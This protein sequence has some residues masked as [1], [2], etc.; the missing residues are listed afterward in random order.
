MLQYKSLIQYTRV[1]DGVRFPQDLNEP[2]LLVYF[3][4]NSTF[5]NDY[6]KL[7]IRR[8]DLRHVVIPIT[9][10]PL[11]RLTPELR[12]Q[13]KQIQMLAYNSNM[14]YPTNKNLLYDTT[15]FTQTVDKT[16][17]PTTYRQRA[18]FLIQNLLRASFQDFADNYKKILIYSIDITKPVNSFVNRKVFALIKQLKENDIYFDDLILVIVDESSARYRQLIRDKSYKFGRVI[19]YLRSIKIQN[20]EEEK[21]E[22]IK[23]ATVKVMKSIAP[24]IEKPEGVKSAV[25]D[26]LKKHPQKAEELQNDELSAD[27]VDRLTVASILYK[28]SGNLEKSNRLAANIPAINVKTAVKKVSKQYEDDLLKK[29]PSVDLSE[30]VVVQT[31]NVPQRVDGKTPEHIFAKRRVDFETNLRKDMINAFKVL[32]GRDIPLKFDSISVKPKPQKPGELS[33]SDEATL[34]IKLKDAKGRVQEVNLDIPRIDPNTGTFRVNGK[35]KCL[36]NQIVLNPISFPKEYD[37]KFESSYS[38]F[39]IYSKRTKRLKYLE[40]YM[41]SFKLPFMILI[42]FSFGFAETLKQYGISYKIVEEKPTGEGYFTKVPSSYLVFENVNSELKEELVSSFI[43]ANIDQYE[44]DIEKNKFLSKEYFNDLIIKMTGRVDSTYLITNNL[45]NIVDPIVRQVLINQQLPFELPMIMQYMANK[46]VIGY[47]Q[48]RNDITHQRIRNSELLVHLAQKQLLK[49]YTEYREQYLAGN[50]DAVLNVPENVVMTQFS[51]LEIVQDME[52][53][54]PLEEMATITKISPV[55]KSVGGIPDKQA[56]QLD[57]RNVHPTYYGNIDPLDTAEGGNIGITQQLT[58]DAYITSARGLF[59]QKPMKDSERSGILSTSAAMVPFIENNEGARIIMS[60]NQAKQMLPLKNPEP[61]IVQSGYES[62]LTNTLSD[63]FIKRA[64]CTGKIGTVTDHYIDIECSKG[65]KQKIDISPVQLRSGVGK[66]TL[67]TFKP[68]V[69]KGQSVKEKQII[70]EGGCISGGT[71]ALGR[72]LAVAYLPYKGYNFEDGLVINERLVEQDK[73]TSLHGLD[74]EALVDA[75]DRIAFIT[76]I[77]A[78]TQKGE[79]LF[80]KYPGDIDELLGYDEDDEDVDTYDG[81]III[82]SP[83]GRVVD[84]EVFANV[85]TDKFPMLKD[86]EARTNRKTKKPE[87]EKYTQRGISIKGIRIL[88]RIEQALKIGLGDKLCNRYGNKNIVSLIES[89]DLMPKTPWGESLDIIL[90]PLGVISRM[91]MGQIYE[92]YCGLISRF[93]ADKISKGMTQTQ[94]VALFSVVMKGLD[95]SPNAKFSTQFI[96]NLKKLSSQQYNKMAAQIKQSGYVPMIMPPFQAPT[97][98]HIIPVLKK[99]GLKSGYKLKLPEFNTSTRTEV[100]FGYLYMAK[101][102]HIGEAKAHSRSTGPMVGKIGQPTGGKSREG[103]QRMGEGDTW[104]LASYNCPILLSEFFGPMSD[105]IV[106]KNEILT[107]IIQTGSADFRPTKASPTKDLLNAY[108]TSMM[109][110]G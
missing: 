47:V 64:P 103:G 24:N 26:Y 106:T 60:C 109:L 83:G 94:A 74:I 44:V 95:T 59:G 101:L 5:V 15:Y 82:K 9:R 105:D 67:S 87:K 3:S 2:F 100:P 22:E 102:E 66:N 73:L 92:M 104:A 12:N 110:R 41:G 42:S 79:P 76:E 81:Q 97:Y 46:C 80:R 54:N 55:G 14:K 32:E 21:Q 50:K 63:S 51:N 98:K 39:H 13:Y 61:P 28:A 108:F 37:S 43:N 36:I 11:T 16:Y 53:A 96:N 91:N 29:Q 19:P 23:Q 57:A 90:N 56:V 86:L 20:T 18:G 93:M 52:Y 25:Q 107:E 33:Q 45:E 30:S 38:S 6:S 1:V 68:V 58:V 4:E 8:V 88:F 75:K 34:S 85:S 78:E 89:D 7:N 40:C 35:R 84:I 99:L 27:D 71:I 65:K 17:E 10:I 69:V 62:L 72:N 48:D 70:A 77:G 31:Q 49:A